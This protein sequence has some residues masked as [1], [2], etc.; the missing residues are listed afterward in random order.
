MYYVTWYNIKYTKIVY[1][2]K[3]IVCPFALDIRLLYTDKLN[4]YKWTIII[5]N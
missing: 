4:K 3:F 2:I 1:D 5:K